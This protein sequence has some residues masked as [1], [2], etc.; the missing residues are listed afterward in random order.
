MPVTNTHW[1]LNAAT[2]TVL[3]RATPHGPD[4]CYFGPALSNST[5]IDAIEA[6][7]DDPILH[8]SVDKAE[9]V[10]L[11][12]QASLAYTGSPG[13]VGH[14]NGR[15]FAHRW[16]LAAAE[17]IESDNRVHFTL[18]DD[19]T[20]LALEL[21][22][23]LDPDTS[24]MSMHSSLTN[25]GDEDFTVDWLASA[26]LPLPNHHTEL[27][28]LH[29][30]WGGEF[31]EYR[32]PIAPGLIDIS[33]RH[34]RT[35]HEHSPWLVTGAA[36]FDE[37]QHDVLAVHLAWSGNTSL[38]VE[39]LADSSG[40]VQVGVLPLPGEWRLAPGATVT[41]PKALVARA[42]GINALSH[43]F[44]E[45]ARRH[46]LPAWTRSAR[47][48]H[49][50]SWEAVYFDHRTDTLL[51]L[52]DACA[53]LGAE[54]FVLDDGWFGRRR[55]DR[56]GLGDWY[57][58]PEVY[59]DG[60]HPIVGRVRQQGMQFG[61]WFEPEM[62]NPDSALYETHP[63]WTLRLDGIETP[64]ARQQWVLDLSLN[65]VQDYLYEHIVALVQEYA[66][67]YIKWDMNRDLVLAGDG[68]CARAASQ[69]EALYTLLSRIQEA[70]PRLEIES[71]SS[72]GARI[73]YGVLAHTGRV[74]TSDNIDPIERARIQAGFLRFYPPEI[75]GAHVGHKAAHLTGR[76]TS[77]HTRAIVA[78]QGQYGFE[79][80]ARRL[81]SD[82]R[83]AL[84]H[85]TALYKANREW[86][87]Q[88]RYYRLNGVDESLI[89]SAQ[90][91]LD[92]AQAWISIV[93]VSAH[94]HSRPGRLR[95]AGLHKTAHYRVTLASSNRDDVAQFS[96]RLPRWMRETPLISGDVLMQLGLPLPVLAPQKA[97]LVSCHVEQDAT[98]ATP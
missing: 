18:T 61:L 88:S 4:L 75:M 45:H 66:I 97:L 13:L 48:I 64:L 85:Y 82:E 60:L 72:G 5:S 59:P 81:D 58:D 32:R 29:G 37:A 70:C 90:V 1:R 6:L 42:D 23:A 9:A 27:M 62:V 67:D 86:L 16:T 53:T 15:Q 73:D 79:I 83:K 69:P 92:Q 14:R 12:P 26:S 11:C 98:P 65:A 41:T 25:T 54:R 78:L 76:E 40:L 36:G 8:A 74:W 84:A 38:K 7:V 43:A 93:A 80:D 47:P 49:A 89:A 28:S 24:I 51:E 3:L 57:V 33:N 94:P 50:N 91:S 96:R 63:E 31:R 39:R 56:A 17:L 22:I 68:Q 2:A 10:T 52:I 34:G 71:C 20:A 44:H 77:L 21:H 55:N 35:S 46:V 95:L 30:R 87:S 19:H